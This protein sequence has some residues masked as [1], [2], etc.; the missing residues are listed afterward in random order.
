MENYWVGVKLMCKVAIEKS[1]IDECIDVIMEHVES[2]SNPMDSYLEEQ[3]FTGVVYYFKRN[4]ERI[5]YCC[6][7]EESI[8][9]F[10]IKKQYFSYAPKIL[11]QTTKELHIN[12]LSVMSQDSL[13]CALIAE[14]DYNMKRGA[15]WFIDSGR[16][17]DRNAK[18][19]N[20]VFRLAKLNDCNT[21]RRISGDFFDEQSCC[22][23]GLED[24]IKAKTIFVLEDNGVFLGGGIIEYG[25]LCKD[26]VSIGMFTN[27]EHRQKGVAKTILL[28]LKEYVYNIGK[29]PVAGCWYYNTLSRKSLE[30]AGM[31]A[32]SIGFEAKL[33]SKDKPP[34]RTGNPPGELIE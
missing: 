22:F 3:L 11:E 23:S 15:C 17:V 31:I 29:K 4:D 30:S 7:K 21:I 10:Y 9:F 25:R 32:A 33:K 34:I 13:M 12:R 1:G 14:W 24:R 19:Q 28:N 6:V 20:A 16:S 27:P 18:A 26:C 2:L 5:G 8:E